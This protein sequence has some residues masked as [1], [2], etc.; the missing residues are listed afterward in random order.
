MFFSLGDE[1][2]H[3]PNFYVPTA[4]SYE[5]AKQESFTPYNDYK[6]HTISSNILL[7]VAI[8]LFI[9]ILY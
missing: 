2:E 1:D 5:A 3:Y 8:L 9:V 4:Y 6:S 7:L